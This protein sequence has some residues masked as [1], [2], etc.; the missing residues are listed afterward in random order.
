MGQ[1][2]EI[3]SKRRRLDS[4]FEVQRRFGGGSQMGLPHMGFSGHDAQ[5]QQDPAFDLRGSSIPPGAHCPH[6][7]AALGDQSSQSCAQ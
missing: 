1:A 2:I 7:A 5:T 4:E 6:W 3:R